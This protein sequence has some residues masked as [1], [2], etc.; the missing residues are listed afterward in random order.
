M[1]KPLQNR[2]GYPIPV[3]FNLSFSIHFSIPLV[4]TLLSVLPLALMHSKCPLWLSDPTPIVGD[5]DRAP[6]VTLKGRDNQISQSGPFLLL[7]CAGCH[8]LHTYTVF[9]FNKRL[10]RNIHFIKHFMKHKT[11]LWMI[12][13]SH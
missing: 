4:S 6:R 9:N 5:N 12:I 7:R 10:G 3:Q 1:D 8:K 2:R 13:F 11:M